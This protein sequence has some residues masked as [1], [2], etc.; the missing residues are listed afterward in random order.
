MICHTQL[1]QGKCARECVCVC[2]PEFIAKELSPVWFSLA[3]FVVLRHL[4]LAWALQGRLGSVA[5]E[6]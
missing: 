3:I 4:L 6:S 1:C 2:K 5:I